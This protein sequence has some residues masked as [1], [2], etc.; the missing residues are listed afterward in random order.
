ML[1]AYTQCYSTFLI[2]HSYHNHF[3]HAG[4]E[5]LSIPNLFMDLLE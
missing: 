4:Q 1:L 5:M 3:S 2:G